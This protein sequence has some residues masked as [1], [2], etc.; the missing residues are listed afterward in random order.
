MMAKHIGPPANNV[1]VL[2]FETTGLSP[3]IGDRA[4]EIGAVLLRDGVVAGRFQ[5]LMN[6]GQRVSQFI[7]DYTGITNDMLIDAA[8]CGDV[9]DRFADFVGDEAVV[10]HNVSFDSRFLDAELQRIGR[11]AGGRRVCSMLTARRVY[12]K[13]PNHKLGT[14]VNYKRLP[15]TGTFHRALADAEMTA[16]LWVQM[17]SDIVDTYRI[18]Q[19]SLRLMET[20]ARKPK[21]KAPEW[22]ASQ[23]AR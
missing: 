10:A 19:V 16:H 14:L 1:V 6:P 9:M 17:L 8:P 22:L 12:P 5:E 20:L 13:A 11:R 3:T 18:P 21:A 15:V 7:E 4:I 2:D 23:G